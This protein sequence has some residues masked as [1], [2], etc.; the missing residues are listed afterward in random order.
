MNNGHGRY[1]RYNRVRRL[2]DLAASS[3]DPAV[4]EALRRLPTEELRILDT[5]VEEAFR[6]REVSVIV[7]DFLKQAELRG[8]QWGSRIG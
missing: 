1:S 4:E 8:G 7:E 5:A 2:E 6:A 3:G